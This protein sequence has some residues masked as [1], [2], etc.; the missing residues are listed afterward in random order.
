LGEFCTACGILW[1]NRGTRFRQK[2]DEFEPDQVRPLFRV[3]YTSPIGNAFDNAPDGQHFVVT[4]LP[5]RAPTPLVFV[6]DWLAE[7]KK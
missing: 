2:K 5:Q 7:L 6:S 4:E 1:P 3:N